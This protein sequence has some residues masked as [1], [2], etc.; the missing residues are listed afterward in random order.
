MAILHDAAEV[1][2][3]SLEVCFNELPDGSKA[4]N[5]VLTT[6]S[7][8][9]SAG[10]SV[11]ELLRAVEDQTELL[12]HD[13]QDFDSQLRNVKTGDTRTGIYLAQPENRILFAST[14]RAEAEEYLE[15]LQNPPARSPRF[16]P[17]PLEDLPNMLRLLAA[18]GV[19]VPECLSK[20][21]RLRIAGNAG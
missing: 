18:Q 10:Q 17:V 6:R 14:C 5:L 16:V 15:N 3:L 1:A 2:D 20:S 13:I 7:I 12:I 9:I 19:E 8:P 4:L 11:S 21:Q